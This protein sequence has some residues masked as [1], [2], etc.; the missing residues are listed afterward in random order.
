MDLLEGERDAD[1]EITDLSGVISEIA[2]MKRQQKELKRGQQR[3]RN[4]R[5][6]TARIVLDSEDTTQ[7]YCQFL[8]S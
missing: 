4:A 7:V 2:K 3:M 8:W 1:D 6:A 5:H